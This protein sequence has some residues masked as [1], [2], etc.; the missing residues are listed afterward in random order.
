[1]LQAIPS[2]YACEE[3][4]DQSTRDS[5]SF[6]RTPAHHVAKAI[7]QPGETLYRALDSDRA[8]VQTSRDH[9]HQPKDEDPA[10]AATLSRARNSE[11]VCHFCGQG[12]HIASLSAHA[13][14]CES[15]WFVTAPE[16]DGDVELLLRVPPPVAS[17]K[18]AD[19]DTD[20]RT[21]AQC[22]VHAYNRLAAQVH[23][24]LC[25][26]G[27]YYAQC[28]VCSRRF[29]SPELCSRHE[30][31]CGN[32]VLEDDFEVISDIGTEDEVLWQGALAT[33]HISDRDAK[34]S[35][36]D[37]R[38][39]LSAICYLCGRACFVPTLKRHLE[40]CITRW[41][42][43]EHA[44]SNET[45]KRIRPLAPKV[46]LPPSENSF[47]SK[48]HKRVEPLK[49]GDGFEASQAADAA[50]AAL[51]NAYNA[52]SG[53][54]YSQMESACSFDENTQGTLKTPSVTP[55]VTRPCPI[56]GWQLASNFFEEHI[57]QCQKEWG[58][59][60][61]SV[62]IDTCHPAPGSPKSPDD[63]QTEAQRQP[64]TPEACV[65]AERE[66]K[67]E[68]SGLEVHTRRKQRTSRFY[69]ENLSSENSEAPSHSCGE[70]HGKDCS[71]HKNKTPAV[72][73]TF[74]VC[75]I[76][77]RRFGCASIG[78]HMMACEQRWER[79]NRLLPET[80]R[81]L[82]EYPEAAYWPPPTA[83]PGLLVT[84]NKIA[85]DLYNRTSGVSC[86]KCQRAFPELSAREKHMSQCCPEERAKIHTKATHRSRTTAGLQGVLG[87]ACVCYICGRKVFSASTIARHMKKC[88]ARFLATAS[89]EHRMP[90]IPIL[91]TNV[92][93]P[94]ASGEASQLRAWNKA[95]E[96]A[97]RAACPLCPG[98]C[99]GRTFDDVIK[100]RQHMAACC[101]DMLRRARDADRRTAILP[102]DGNALG[103]ICHICGRRILSSMSLPFHFSSCLRRFYADE[104]E[105]PAAKQRRPT[106]PP[107]L[108]SWSIGDK[109]M[110]S[111]VLPSTSMPEIEQGD[112]AGEHEDHSSE[113]YSEDDDH[114]DETSQRGG[115]ESITLCYT[116][117]TVRE[118]SST[119][120]NHVIDCRSRW[121]RR[122][123]LR[124]REWR[125]PLP[126]ACYCTLPGPAMSD[127]LLVEWN[128][129][130]EEK[131]N[132]STANLCENCG[133]K[134]SQRSRL[135][136]HEKGCV[137]RPK[138]NCGTQFAYGP[139]GES[140]LRTHAKLC[141]T[142]LDAKVAQSSAALAVSQPG[143]FCYLCGRRC[144]LSSLHLHVPR[145]KEQWIRRTGTHHRAREAKMDEMD[146]CD[147]DTRAVNFVGA[148][149]LPNPPLL[150]IPGI[151][152]SAE[153]CEAYSKEAEAIWRARCPSCPLCLR[154]FDSKEKLRKHQIGGCPNIEWQI[155]INVAEGTSISKLLSIL[156][157]NA[158][159]VLLIDQ[160]IRAE[161]AKISGSND[162]DKVRIE[163]AEIPRSN[164]NHEF[165]LKGGVYGFKTSREAQLARNAWLE[166]DVDKETASTCVFHGLPD[167]LFHRKISL[168]GLNLRSGVAQIIKFASGE[169]PWPSLL[170]ALSAS[171]GSDERG[172]Q[173]RNA[174]NR[175]ANN[176][177]AFIAGSAKMRSPA[178]R[179]NAYAK[180]CEK[181]NHA[182]SQ[183]LQQAK[184]IVSTRGPDRTRPRHCHA[185]FRRKREV[186]ETQRNNAKISRALRDIYSY[187]KSRLEQLGVK[188][189]DCSK[190]FFHRTALYSKGRISASPTHNRRQ[191]WALEPE[192]QQFRKATNTSDETLI[193]DV[194]KGLG[195]A[196]CAAC[197]IMAFYGNDKTPMR[198]C[199]L[200]RQTYYCTYNIAGSKLLSLTLS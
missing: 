156:S 34:D 23:V 135:A 196:R 88:R 42:M 28:S 44:T 198:P 55:N 25:R 108:T 192:G 138:C 195:V 15:R 95:A 69:S 118:K 38:D 97:F 5:S 17:D 161:I 100:L 58:E 16:V 1:M 107:S 91:P 159:A 114:V 29:S 41:D 177:A 85:S 98:D 141:P 99:C 76:C 68:L 53:A 11:A 132:T 19:H 104:D 67:P 148:H 184:A 24:E 31:A 131:H 92:A 39:T 63:Q 109:Y 7:N 50:A 136:I 130:A 80:A 182:L 188:A 46:P 133:R 3:R 163:A 72:P 174:E 43:R 27:S 153:E 32:A 26:R 199:P 21:A 6:S 119:I 65:D 73:E 64:P 167:T 169:E 37:L 51:L 45:S 111:I 197:G 176:S 102:R 49:T 82:L 193:H 151:D 164:R 75:F 66:D 54:I 35:N 125:R 147:A 181:R 139:Q 155:A 87:R 142:A 57:D 90:K 74:V 59:Q 106:S 79:E 179:Q 77:G 47:Y 83:N 162:L 70:F 122:E 81:R 8:H 30:H 94:R 129:S 4:A 171:L 123:R 127:G 10:I 190:K 172:T 144:L 146:R 89:L 48:Y 194:P 105:V 185:A 40:R 112:S 62:S 33:T 13:K 200:C 120:V 160:I 170:S 128:K 20:S 61:L 2:P 149:P 191:A 103:I 126:D 166:H 78:R 121:R 140:A 145:C 86:L 137:P 134:F 9:L 143:V 14:A 180:E 165:R 168:M 116:C 101:P 84:Y 113:D 173:V 12:I 189:V 158:E 22:A 154:T 115:N 187:P 36:S 183:R 186:L 175:Y 157:F 117:C 18:K 152:S 56:C 150:P 124:P 60:Q 71:R 52:E 93:L 178:C 96:D 110:N